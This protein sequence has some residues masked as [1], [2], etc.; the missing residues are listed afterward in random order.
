M[1]A[2]QPI[3]IMK[4]KLPLRN[5]VTVLLLLLS[6]CV[7]LAR[8]GQPPAAPIQS[9]AA[10][11][12]PQAAPAIDPM[13]GL[14][15]L[16]PTP[17]KD[18]NWNDPDKV[19]PELTYIGLAI[20]EV[21]RSL[22]D[23]FKGQFDIILPEDFGQG[24]PGNNN[25]DWNA[26]TIHLRLQNVRASEVFNAMN[27]LF[28]NDRIPLRWELKMNG[29]RRLALLRV[30]TDPKPDE[31]YHKP[32][33]NRI[34]YV[35]DLIGDDQAA[36][37]STNTADLVKTVSEVWKMSFPESGKIQFHEKAQLLIVT[38]TDEE[39]RFMAETLDAMRTR[40][41]VEY[42]RRH[43][44]D[45]KKQAAETKA[46]KETAKTNDGGGPK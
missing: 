11:A 2:N 41:R 36:G 24:L 43:E 18:A 20:S 39:I 8:G 9:P 32:E 17:W 37:M 46:A 12:P 29:N 45:L 25:T 19:I 42:T 34:Y 13:T 35:G 15:V 6:V 23:A 22:G 26:T 31:T 16:P 27:L 3:V 5:S 10:P 21:A 38:G 44:A 7:A 1:R 4:S 40:F 14:P 30:K 28:E 33:V